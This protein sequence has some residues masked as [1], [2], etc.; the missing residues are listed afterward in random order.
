MMPLLPSLSRRWK[1]I[2]VLA[3]LVA[4]SADNVGSSPDT[5]TWSNVETLGGYLNCR[6]KGAAQA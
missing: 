5:V 4:L 3:R 1:L 2:R 6:R